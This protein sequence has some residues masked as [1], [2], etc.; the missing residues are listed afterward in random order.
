MTPQPTPARIV[1]PN[2]EVRVGWFDRPFVYPNLQDARPQHALAG[3]H[4]GPFQGLEKRFRRWRLKQWQYVS[5]VTDST[6]F[7]CAVVDVGYLG[8]AFAYVVNRH[9]GER[10]EWAA[11]QP[12]SQ[13]VAVAQSSIKGTSRFERRNWGHIDIH[14]HPDNHQ[15]VVSV[16]LH[17][18]LGAVPKPPLR[19]ELRIFDDPQHI[20]PIV[21]VEQSAPKLWLYTHK[22]YGLLVEG[23]LQCG[24]IQQRLQCGDGLAGFDYNRGYRQRRT[25]WNWAAASGRTNDG[26]IVGFNLTA[27]RPWTT[28]G[29][30]RNTPPDA[31]DCGF[32]LDG[33][34]TKLSR[35]DFAY[36]PDS[37][38]EPWHI[39]DAD[40]LVDLHF[41][42]EGKRSEHT[43]AGIVTSL[44][45]QPYGH[46]TGTLSARA[47]RKVTLENVYGV[48]EQH[49]A[50][51]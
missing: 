27:H 45:H 24:T 35:V 29:S 31:A 11:K 1:E 21:V 12:L 44:F 10:F 42:P 4:G 33:T 9:T 18:E 6:L 39:F 34:L 8:S 41:A 49:Y 20:Q 48:T 13:R 51:W 32:W 16:R 46:F 28:Q 23:S 5:V 30:Q 15:R 47:G 17:G 36:N 40:G 19:V 22:S 50:L 43:H 7:A 25:W 26:T 37:L 38:L 3:L 2:G 14:N